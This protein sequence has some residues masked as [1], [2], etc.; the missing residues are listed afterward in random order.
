MLEGDIN[1]HIF[2]IKNKNESI[3]NNSHSYRDLIIFPIPSII[4]ILSTCILIT[5]IYQAI[6]D[7]PNGLSICFSYPNEEVIR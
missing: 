1:D 5:Q 2:S 4:L 6:N 7:I 3:C